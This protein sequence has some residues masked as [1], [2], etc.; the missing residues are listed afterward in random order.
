MSMTPDS[1][2]NQ[3]LARTH[4]SPKAIITEA[5]GTALLPLG[6][7]LLAGSLSSA[8]FAQA[9]HDQLGWPTPHL[10]FMGERINL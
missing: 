7:M 6:A 4:Q 5:G 9:I 2:P 8:A 1:K 10:P 3:P